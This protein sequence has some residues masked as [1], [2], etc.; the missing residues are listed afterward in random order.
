MSLLRADRPESSRIDAENGQ[1]M[2]P[3][4]VLLRDSCIGLRQ[5]DNQ[6]QDLIVR[7]PRLVTDQTNTPMRR[8]HAIP[9]ECG[10]RAADDCVIRFV[11][12]VYTC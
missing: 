11:D 7:L 6:T 10:Y 9:A 12:R 1:T 3:P 8:Q 4:R 2:Y 5:N